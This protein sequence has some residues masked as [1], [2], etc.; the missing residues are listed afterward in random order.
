MRKM[1]I[2]QLQIS[3]NNPASVC[4]CFY[5]PSILLKNVNQM[6][7]RDSV[8]INLIARTLPTRILNLICHFEFFILLSQHISGC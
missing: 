7:T 3:L 4:I 1:K 8:P 6:D 5:G 2:N